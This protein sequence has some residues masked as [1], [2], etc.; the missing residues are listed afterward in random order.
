MTPLKFAQKYYANIKFS[1]EGYRLATE[2]MAK[3]ID[4]HFISRQLKKTN[5]GQKITS[6][7]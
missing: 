3:E 7:S 1:Q 6:G 4:K 5:D 2:A